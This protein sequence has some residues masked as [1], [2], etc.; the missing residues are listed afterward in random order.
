ME[1]MWT[2]L[3][4]D[5]D[6]AWSSAYMNLSDFSESDISVENNVI[7]FLILVSMEVAYLMKVD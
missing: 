1:L 3:N 6:G 5:K 7:N 4:M 2:I